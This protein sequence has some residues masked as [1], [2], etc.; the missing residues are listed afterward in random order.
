MVNFLLIS[1]F[2]TISWRLHIFSTFQTPF[3]WARREMEEKMVLITRA[4]VKAQLQLKNLAWSTTLWLHQSTVRFMCH[5]GFWL[6]TGCN[7]MT[8]F[9]VLYITWFTTWDFCQHNIYLLTT[10]SEMS[11]E[12]KSHPQWIMIAFF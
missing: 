6:S 8:Y 9:T 7:I 5:W 2:R 12:A 10:M 1:S 11:H 4:I 3:L